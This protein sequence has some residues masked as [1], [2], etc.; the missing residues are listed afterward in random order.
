MAGLPAHSAWTGAPVRLLLLALSAT[1][2]PVATVG[3]LSCGPTDLASRDEP[4][5]AVSLL[6]AKLQLRAS[7]QRAPSW[8]AAGHT[9]AA[10]L[11]SSERG[12]G[13]AAVARDRAKVP[14]RPECMVPH[15][16]DVNRSIS[17]VL[18]EHPGTDGACY[19]GWLATGLYECAMTHARQDYRYMA[20]TM[21][22]GAN[23]SVWEKISGTWWNATYDGGTF[24]S[25]NY[26]YPFDDLHCHAN[27]FLN[28]QRLPAQ[29]LGSY[30]AWAEL[31]RQE[32]DDLHK[33]F[34]WEDYT[35]LD[36]GVW[37]AEASAKLMAAA[38]GTEPRPSVWEMRRY[39]SMKCA[40]GALDCDMAFCVA[41]GCLLDDGYI[42]R[43]AS[44]HPECAVEV[45]GSFRSA[46]DL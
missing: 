18:S 8:R 37:L 40:L 38:T 11:A 43:S 9:A 34:S 24:R 17:Q 35:I 33:L 21:S 5:E 13:E 42:G 20:G 45:V 39:A 2:A 31:A 23:A 26:Y 4:Y 3:G 46:W 16:S 14:G 28:G 36:M 41:N 6:Q 10:E 7:P 44:G 19:Y 30:T 29:A 12:S 32:C 1:C 15:D 25:Q 27:G 22:Y